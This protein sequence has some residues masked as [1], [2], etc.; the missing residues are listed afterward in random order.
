LS[1]AEQGKPLRGVAAALLLKHCGA[2]SKRSDVN[3]ITDLALSA[4]VHK[5][6]ASHVDYPNASVAQRARRGGDTVGKLKAAPEIPAGTARQ[7][8]QFG[9]LLGVDDA[10]GNF[11]NSA[12]TAASDDQFCSLLCSFRGQH[13]SVTD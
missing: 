3:K 7:N 8:A 5:S 2:H 1:R 12:I 4:V 9:L 6:H 10:V 13:S 11:R